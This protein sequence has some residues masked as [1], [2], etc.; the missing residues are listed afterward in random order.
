V[1]WSDGAKKEL[2][3]DN[4]LS[5]IEEELNKVYKRIGKKSYDEGKFKLASKLFL[6]MCTST[7][8]PEFL[9]SYAYPFIVEPKCDGLLLSPPTSAPLTCFCLLSLTR[10]L[11]ADGQL[12]NGQE[13]TNFWLEVEDTKRW[14]QDSRWQDTVRHYSPGSQ[15]PYITPPHFAVLIR[16]FSSQTEDVVRLR[17]EF[18]QEYASNQTAKKAW[19]LF[20]HLRETKGY[21]HT[22]GAL[23]PVQVI[24]MAPYLTTVYVSGWQCSSTASTSNDPGAPHQPGSFHLPA[25]QHLPLFLVPFRP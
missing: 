19:K 5:V 12:V 2:T 15:S 16:S 9:T 14:W 6:D 24:S 10:H 20:T 4:L 23:D 11:V 17:G 25:S 8:P 7:N 3:R 1:S 21:S 18:K 22:F 13:E